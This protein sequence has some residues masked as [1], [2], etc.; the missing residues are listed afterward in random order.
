[1]INFLK[2]IFFLIVLVSTVT[3]T[4]GQDQPMLVFTGKVTDVSGKKLDGVQV[5]IKQ[6]N[7]PFETKTTGSNGKYDIIEAPFGH[8]YTLVFKKDGMVSKTLV[9]DTKKGYFEEDVEPRTFIEPS[10]SL[11]KRDDDV[12]YD[13]IENQ[14]VGK[15]R[16]DPQ[17]GKLDWDYAFSGQ[18]KNEIDRYLKQIEQ[19]AR[20]KEA[21]FKKMVNEG[22]AAYNKEDYNLAIIKYEEAISIKAD[23]TISAKIVSA[24][25][26]LALKQSQKEQQNQY[27]ALINKGNDALSSNNFDGATDFYTQ[28]KNLLPGNQIA[29]DKLREVEQKKQ[30]LAD[31]EINAQFKAKMDL[32]NAAFEKK[33]WENAKNIYKEASSI[34]PNDRSPKDRIIEIDNLLAK[35]KSDEEDY[36]NFITKGDQLLADKNFD[37]AISNYQKASNIKPEEVYPKDQIEKAKKEKQQAEAQAEL[38]RQYSNLIKTADYQLKNLSY[39]NA[40]T[41]YNEALKL[42]PDEQY[43]KDQISAIDQ[44]LQDIQAENDRLN[45]QKKDYDDQIVIADKLYNEEKWQESTEAYKKAQEIKPDEVYP[46][47]KI[48]EINMKLQHLAAVENDKRK[49][50]NEN[51]QKGDA[52]FSENNWKLAKQYYSDASTVF[53]TEKYP[54]DQ[55]ALI[56]TKLQE[57]EQAKLA[58]SQKN[59]QFDAFLQEGDLLLEEQNFSN[60]KSKYLEAKT[61]FPDRS[62]VDQ[63][64]QHLNTLYEMYLSKQKKDSVYNELITAADGLFTSK[65]WSNAEKKYY[66]A[67]EIKPL[68]NYPKSQLELIANNLKDE[69][70]QS[71]KSQYDELIKKGDDNLSQKSYKDALDY[72]DQAN[73]ILPNEPYPL[74]KIREIKRILSDEEEKENNYKMLINQADNQFESENWEKAL[75][76]YESAKAIF[77]RDYPNNQITKINTKLTEL[78]DQQG[79]DAQNRAAYDN[80]IKEAD[81]LFLEEKYQESKDKFNEAL[82]LFANEYYPKKKIFEIDAKLKTLNSEKE[83]VEKYNQLITNADQLRDNKKWVEAKKIYGN[84]FNLMPEKEYPQEQINFINE[85]MKLETQQEFQVQYDK[86]IKAADDQFNNKEYNKAKEL[87]SRARNMNAEDNYPSQRIT[88]IDQILLEMASNKLDE[89]RF[90][91]NKEKYDQL[92]SKANGLRDAEQWEK[93]KEL[94]IQANKVLPSETYP[95]EQI[96]FINQKMKESAAAEIEKQYNKVIDMADKFFQDEKYEKS[97]NLYRRAQSLKPDDAYPPEQIK[98]VE[99]AKMVAFNKE[100]RQQEF[101]LLIKEGKRAFESRNYRL[102]LKK[103][104]ESLKINKEAKFP[105]QKI[106]EINDILDKQKSNNKKNDDVAVNPGDFRTLYGEEVTGKY[107]EDQIDALMLQGHIDDKDDLTSDA[108]LQKDQQDNFSVKNREQQNELTFLQNEQVQSILTKIDRSFD[109][110]DD[111]RWKIIPQVDQYKDQRSF[112]AKETSSFSA[113][114]TFRTDESFSRLQTNDANLSLIRDENISLQNSSF[115]NYMDEKLVLDRDMIQRG[116]SITYDNALSKEMIYTDIDLSNLNRSTNQNLLIDALENFKGSNALMYETNNTYFENTTYTNYENTE[117]VI[118]KYVENFSLSDDKRI[119]QTL[120]AFVNYKDGYLT[121]SAIIANEGVDVTYAQYDGTQQLKTT[122]NNFALNAD[123][124]RE[125]NAFN[126]DHY[127]DKETQK[128]SVWGDKSQDKVYNMHLVHEMIDDEQENQFANKE[129]LRNINVSELDNYNDRMMMQKSDLADYDKKGDYMNAQRLDEMKSKT[130]LSNTDINTQKLALEYPEGIT[131]KMFQRT[132]SR[133]D[134]IEVTILRIVVRGN[135]GDQ[136]KKV[137]SKWG[138]SFFK[139]GGITTEYIW[140]TETN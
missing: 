100:K 122:L 102:A 98:K 49:R 57:E 80:F 130:A 28:A 3:I 7:K 81:Q 116:N 132:N 87:Y 117:T 8:L 79:K 78:R 131:E 41:T 38:D 26:N 99:E 135:K 45:K 90:K 92:I 96:T 27:D 55:I 44:K 16:I 114:K 129:S 106:K 50:Y 97:L 112:Y 13:I 23:E 75:V 72:F 51:I 30:D 103:F 138:E 110:S 61:L 101:G 104:N 111:P 62:I 83:T 65:D 113:E 4:H 109:N 67:L 39:E 48:D 105:I 74:D 36:S 93:S 10:I 33:E 71:I 127:L 9:L 94:Y 89:E 35:M 68:E 6:D 12:D 42:K 69:A 85:Q 60:A 29:Y 70:Q 115:V 91:A 40:K 84:A 121:T 22:N 17:S 123:I 46:K 136:Y 77:D 20:Q 107:S 52:A 2:K 73:E 25:K 32:A 47:Q 126:L 64:L 18:R 21:Q 134:I 124:P 82:S 56:E 140:D 128:L 54:V 15:A 1:M 34:K 14:P 120:P 66:D 108:E 118:T 37:D 43:P 58:E 31:A 139:N 125:E 53:D 133:G 59:Q 24:K 95:Q 11:I 137:K 119:Q 88:E 63:K 76:S 19:A 5:V 86:L